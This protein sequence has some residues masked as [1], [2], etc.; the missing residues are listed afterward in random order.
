MQGDTICVSLFFLHRK[1]HLFAPWWEWVVWGAFL[2][3][4]GAPSSTIDS[5]FPIMPSPYAKHTLQS[6]VLTAG[7]VGTVLVVR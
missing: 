5:P 4:W 6:L 3:I 7:L 2:C 1:L